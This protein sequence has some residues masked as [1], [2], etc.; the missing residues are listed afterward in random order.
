[1]VTNDVGYNL[2]QDHRIVKFAVTR[3]PTRE[4]VRQQLMD[5]EQ[6]LDHVVYIIH[7]YAAQ[8]N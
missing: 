5:F 2:S 6:I 1:M 3:N 4:F 7:D 8:F